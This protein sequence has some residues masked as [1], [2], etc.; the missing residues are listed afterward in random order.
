M[1]MTSVS[2]I[3]QTQ[4]ALFDVSSIGLFAQE[5]EFLPVDEAF[6]FNFHQKEQKL[7]IS[8]DIA[9]DYY[10]YRK[11]FKF[12]ANNAQIAD[13]ELPLGEEYHDEFSGLQQIY[14]QKVSFDINIE[15][16]DDL[17]EL[18]IRYQGCAS[19]GLCYPPE[20]KK[21]SLSA[22]SNN[23][24]AILAAI[25][26]TEPPQNATKT[27]PLSE[28]NQLADMLK[29][30]SL[31]VTLVAFFFGG[32]LLSF[33]PCVF[34][35]YP[36]LT[37]IIVG[38]GKNQRNLTTKKAFTLSFF[39]V[40]GM[41]I[42]YTLLGIAVALI[43]G[44]F[45]ALFQHPYVL[46][47]LSIL[48]IF[49]ALSMFGLFNLALPSRWQNSL[50]NLSNKQQGGS[51]IGVV[52][53][54]VISGL[55]ASPCTTAPLTGALLYISQ[56]GDILLGA[57]AL[58]ALSLGMGLPLLILGSSG[59]K[60]LP[61]AGAWMNVIKN[62]FG[63]LLLAVPVFLLDR[64]IPPMASQVLWISLLL[65]SSSYF[66]VLNQTESKTKGFGYGARSLI[67]F[68]SLFIGA[69]QAYQ[70][71]FDQG[72]TKPAQTVQQQEF[73][74][75]NSLSDLQA[76][77]QQANMQG[78]SVMVDLYADWCVACKEFEHYTFPD[79]QVQNALAKTKLVKIDLTETNT[80]N[81]IKIMQH[82]NIFGLPSILFFNLQGKELN[83]NR[84]TGFMAAE[85]F[86]QHINAILP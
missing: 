1:M 55:V 53:M 34:P 71:A 59:G 32:L 86:A 14:H 58:Y 39:Y 77:V 38:H 28:Q 13:V 84:V 57:S 17:A 67:I 8:F 36:I 12:T 43:G 41:A 4:P 63:L 62:I 25:Q 51:I 82:F 6:I 22:F 35:M 49:L 31:L 73:T 76:F 10:L 72:N 16:A 29:E 45:Q 5:N 11:Q 24:Q 50:N 3:G 64:I 69:Q 42:T 33:T 46:I 18:S 2:S 79:P 83:E 65:I 61:K 19:A 47:G 81:N 7:T 85:E 56:T 78:K 26:Q 40:Q 54:G 23:N 15:Q 75:I 68:L 21:I 60:L 30:K 27:A 52:M 9:E 44:Q 48:F 66:Y 20:T 80:P 70:L 37:G 74:N